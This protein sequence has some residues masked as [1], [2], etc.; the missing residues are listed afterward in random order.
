MN[1]S[2]KT[3]LL[4]CLSVTLNSFAQN[5][6]KD[7]KNRWGFLL[8]SN[9]NF[10]HMNKSA[11]DAKSDLGW[12]LGNFYAINFSKSASV[13]I[14]AHVNVEKHTLTDKAN[15]FSLK[16]K[17]VNIAAPLKLRLKLY[18]ELS[19]L[20]GIEYLYVASKQKEELKLQK[21]NILALAGASYAIKFKHFTAVPELSYRLGL[22]NALE[23]SPTHDYDLTRSAVT[24]GVKIM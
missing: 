23:K 7:E 4:I 15:N 3:A 8:K 21:N 6:S 11:V 18:E 24:F 14:E 20:S 16:L 9:F 22:N 10:F 17:D 2:K 1:F 12:G 19:L 5:T 13:D